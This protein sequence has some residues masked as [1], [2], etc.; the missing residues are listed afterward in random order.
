MAAKRSAAPS[1]LRAPGRRLLDAVTSQFELDT[2]ELELLVQLAHTAD[3]MA[4]L[5]QLVDA[6]GAMVRKDLVGPPRPHPALVELRAQ[7]TVYV[8]LM[9]ALGLPAGLT[10]GTAFRERSTK[11]NGL[12]PVRGA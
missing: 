8:R 3:T 5:Q 10:E 12:H 11:F 9:A 1:G 4:D 2:H 7:R 6:D